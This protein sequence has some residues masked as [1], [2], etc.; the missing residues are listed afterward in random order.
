MIDLVDKNFSYKFSH[1]H[2]L[3]I[4][5]IKGVASVWISIAPSNKLDRQILY[6]IKNAAKV[7]YYKVH[8]SKLGFGL[9][10][11]PITPLPLPHTISKTK[12]LPKWW[13]WVVDLLVCNFCTIF[14]YI[15]NLPML[16]IWRGYR[17]SNWCCPFNSEDRQNMR[18]IKFAGKI[19][20]YKVHH[21]DWWS[22][23]NF[24]IADLY[25]F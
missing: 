5:V 7:A 22:D 4:F 6:I 8:G 16:I 15:Q 9:H 23:W 19:F 13:F 1:L 25:Y 20:V 12:N 2:I 24:Q 11:A 21:S 18:M 17:N 3:P 10:N 14:G